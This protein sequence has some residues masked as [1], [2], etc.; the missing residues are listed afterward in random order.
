MVLVSFLNELNLNT[1]PD[2]I[3]II[4]DRSYSHL[5]GQHD[6][7]VALQHLHS[8]AVADVLKAHP[9]SSQDLITHLYSILLS[10]TTRIQP[11]NSQ[12]GGLTDSSVGARDL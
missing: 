9:V 2:W 11:G 10:Q 5:D 7:C 12:A 1:Q 3:L 4:S 8:A 6:V